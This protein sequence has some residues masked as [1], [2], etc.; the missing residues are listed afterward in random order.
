MT[1]FPPKLV[2]DG[3]GDGEGLLPRRLCESNSN[4]VLLLIELTD[5][6]SPIHEELV[7]VLVE[8]KDDKLLP[9]P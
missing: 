1:L 4:D 2:L 3:V 8:D 7:I 6:R 9:S 5:S